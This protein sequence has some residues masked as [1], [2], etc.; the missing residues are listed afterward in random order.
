[1]FSCN[2]IF[3]VLFSAA[4]VLCKSWLPL[5]H[6]YYIYLT[7]YIRLA[8]KTLLYTKILKAFLTLVHTLSCILMIRMFVQ[9]LLKIFNSSVILLNSSKFSLVTHT[10]DDFEYLSHSLIFVLSYPSL[11]FWIHLLGQEWT[12][13]GISCLYGMLLCLLVMTSSPTLTVLLPIHKCISMALSNCSLSWRFK[14][15]LR[16]FTLRSI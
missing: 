16:L 3:V 11:K 15:S 7:I 14:G 5:A 4:H 12:A 13:S 2:T 1:M 6:I 10:V 8:T 9:S